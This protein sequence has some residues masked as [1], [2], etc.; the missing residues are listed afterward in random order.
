MA[1]L[2]QADFDRDFRFREARK[3]GLVACASCVNCS[4]TANTSGPM[5][6][7]GDLAKCLHNGRVRPVQLA[8]SW[9]SY[10]G[11]GDHRN[12]TD[13]SKDHVC[14][15]YQN[16]PLPEEVQVPVLAEGQGA[17]LNTQWRIVFI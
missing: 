7:S 8:K 2:K 12:Y 13:L 15:A 11:R 14:D 4:G 1:K 3:G 17:L 5:Q 9:G 6:K 16:R 10:W